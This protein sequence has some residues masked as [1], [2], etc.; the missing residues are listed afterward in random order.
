MIRETLVPGIVLT[1]GGVYYLSVRELPQESTVFP[2]FLMGLM[3]VLIVL[4]LAQEY[5]KSVADRAK[6]TNSEKT[7]TSAKAD[8]KSPA[9]VFV[10]SI[11]YLF[12]FSLL[13][14]LA[15]SFAYIFFIMI[16]FGIRP[17]RSAIT[18]ALFT[19][20]LYVVFRQMFFVDL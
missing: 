10:G 17:T 8:L 19:A 2:Y 12:I 9:I 13:G 20:A 11:G 6:T 5:R 3:P 15:A 18:S 14:F 16:Y 1:F 7:P 4:I